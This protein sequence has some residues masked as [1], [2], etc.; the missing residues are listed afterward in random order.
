MATFALL[1]LEVDKC[2]V[3][4]SPTTFLF[5]SLDCQKRAMCELWALESMRGH[6]NTIDSVFKV[7]KIDF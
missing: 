5:R 6:M 1:N 4:K 3:D 2:P 7:K